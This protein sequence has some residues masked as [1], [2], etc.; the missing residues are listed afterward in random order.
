MAL[1]AALAWLE[2]ARLIELG[3]SLRESPLAPLFVLLAFVG[4]G[5]ILFPVVVLVAVTAAVFGPLLG[6]STR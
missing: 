5:L 1:H 6:A 2:P 3:E 4:G